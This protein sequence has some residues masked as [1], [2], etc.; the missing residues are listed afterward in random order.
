MHAVSEGVAGGAGRVQ[1]LHCVG[2]RGGVRGV[3]GAFVEGEMHPNGRALRQGVEC[4]WCAG[5]MCVCVSRRGALVSP[6][7]SWLRCTGLELTTAGHKSF[8][9]FEL[10]DRKFL[11]FPKIN[12]MNLSESRARESCTM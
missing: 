3:G 1:R 9:H 7:Q 8:T 2:N 10:M 4:C 6:K 11:C 5:C 12:W